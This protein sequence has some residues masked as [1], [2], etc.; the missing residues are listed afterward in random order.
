MRRAASHILFRVW[1]MPLLLSALLVVA[2]PTKALAAG[3][4]VVAIGNNAGHAGDVELR[5]AERDA[6]TMASVL[7]RLGGVPPEN[8]TVVLGQDA[9]SIVRTLSVVSDR[10]G[11][12]PSHERRESVFIVFYSGHAD[13]RGLHPGMSTLAYSTLEKLVGDAPAGVRLLVIDGCRSGGITRVKGGKKSDVFEI[14]VESSLH[15]S[16]VAIISSSAAGED[17]HESDLLQGS[18]FSHHFANALRGV[19]DYD[20]DGK[21]TLSE[22]YAYA[23]QQTLRSSAST[24]ALQHPTFD[25]RLSGRGDVV[26]SQPGRFG[27]HTG[28]LM[29]HRPGLYLILRATLAGTVAAELQTS[30][31][32]QSINLP[33]GRY[34]VQERSEKFYYEYPVN[35]T[36]GNAV[37][38]GA[39]TPRR[40][41]YARLVRK[42]GPRAL[43][44]SLAL[45]AAVRGPILE[46]YPMAP[47]WLLAYSLHLP[48][49]TAGMRGRLAMSNATS[50]RELLSSRTMEG[51]LGLTLERYVDFEPLSMSFGLWGE[52]S[53][54]QQSLSGQQ[55]EPDR[56]ALAGAFGSLFAVE[57]D[58]LPE[59]GVRLEGGAVSY[60]LRQV[61]TERGVESG[62]ELTTPVTFW[63]GGGLSWR[64]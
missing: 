55:R 42:G 41:A 64:L 44:H 17:S 39:V 23:Y 50:E 19:A 27:Q 24:M 37:D 26:L 63:A 6:S 62:Y 52:A 12:L 59:L 2:L 61:K 7:V 5:Y 10:I 49:F 30:A 13:A 38:L 25:K 16:G 32:N 9:S 56:R 40:E 1:I 29:L 43:S 28:R 8:A 48:W 20:T 33:P 46:G 14:G 36:T 47:H 35:I 21:V 4:F 45:Q 11:A 31:V 3:I 34:V 54:L 53:Y 57:W 15:T 18:F 22:A 60:F 51:G 58:A